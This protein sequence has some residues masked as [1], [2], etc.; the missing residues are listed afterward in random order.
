VSNISTSVD[1][2]DSEHE[3]SA[4]ADRATS[5][6]FDENEAGAIKPSVD[7]G[8]LRIEPRR[9]MLLRLEVDKTKDR[10]VAVTLESYGSTL[11]LQPFAA[12]RS[13]GLWHG[14]R[15]QIEAQIKTQGGTVSQ[16]DGPFGPELKAVVPVQAEGKYG[17]RPV[18]FLGIDGPRWF[19]RAVIGGDAATDDVAAEAMH[20][21]I[22]SVV[23]VRGD[24]PMPPRDL[25]PLR[26]PPAPG[27][28][29]TQ[30]AG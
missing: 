5:G 14:I 28:T 18:R 10:V 26:V 21:I 2:G 8:S 19:L 30:G 1:A 12:P 11:Q 22:R 24:T 15:A 29:G 3:K 17:T 4:P 16:V 23:V 9:G 20:A 25:L 7:L 6:P 27:D 13:S